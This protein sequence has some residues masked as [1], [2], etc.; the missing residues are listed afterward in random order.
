MSIK[1]FVDYLNAKNIRMRD[2]AGDL[3]IIA[4]D[5][6][7]IR[8]KAERTIVWANASEYGLVEKRSE[9][10]TEFIL[11]PDE[12]ERVFFKL[13]KDYLCDFTQG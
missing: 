12:I 7:E 9:G 2:I 6:R 11:V 10:T 8:V 3:V 5:G 1:L 4:A 13:K